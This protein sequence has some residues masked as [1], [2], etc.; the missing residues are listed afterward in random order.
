MSV[1]IAKRYVKALIEGRDSSAVDEK[2][3]L[4]LSFVENCSATTINLVKLLGENKRLDLLAQISDELN[5]ELASISNNYTGIVYTKE[6][7]SDE[8][9]ATLQDKFSQKFNISLTL[10]QN[11]CDYDG[12]KVDIE[13]LGVEIGLSKDRLRSQLKEYILKA[14]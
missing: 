9:I 12:I 2:V 4:I 6:S 3:K 11:I 5:K 1:L 7:L 10:T 13:G 8:Y 14:I